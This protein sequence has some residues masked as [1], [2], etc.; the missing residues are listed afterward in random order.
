MSLIGKK[1][2]VQIVLNSLTEENL[3]DLQNLV[4]NL[5]E[6]VEVSLIP[7]DSDYIS[8]EMK[9]VHYVSMKLNSF[10][11]ER[12]H[13]ILCYADSGLCGLFAFQDSLEYMK[14]IKI[15]ISSNTFESLQEHLSADEFRRV[16]D[17]S[18]ETQSG[19]ELTP[20][21]LALMLAGSSGTYVDLDEEDGVVIVGL[22]MNEANPGD[23]L[24][25]NED[26]EN[27]HWEQP[28][29]SLPDWLVVED[30]NIR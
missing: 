21:K 14:S 11:G 26:G 16:L 8:D 18:L 25:V 29:S 23:V 1:P 19:G 17:D 7:T 12:I 13:G 20:Y 2:F 3:I 5:G 10:P 27:V 6:P 4:N 15:N 22:D 30:I 24:V 28:A 9:G